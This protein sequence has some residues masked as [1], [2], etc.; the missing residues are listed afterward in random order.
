MNGTLAIGLG[1]STM[2]SRVQS[3]SPARGVWAR[4]FLHWPPPGAATPTHASCRCVLR[5]RSH[6]SAD[7]TATQCLK[8]KQPVVVHQRV[9]VQCMHERFV[10]E[11][12]GLHESHLWLPCR[13]HHRT[14]AS[15]GGRADPGPVQAHQCVAG[16]VVV[17]VQG[18]GHIWIGGWLAG[19]MAVLTVHVR[20]RWPAFCLNGVRACQLRWWMRRADTHPH[21]QLS[22]ATVM[23]ISFS[24]RANIECMTVR[25]AEISVC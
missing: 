9:G 19:C 17:A 7:H 23:G 20:L 13:S 6:V 4:R 12:A 11:V 16:F 21:L 3:P 15:P 24:Q 14:H 5:A 18:V 2:I 10:G 8:L 25:A 22:T 1:A